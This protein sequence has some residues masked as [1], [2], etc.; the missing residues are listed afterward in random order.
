MPSF[1]K[2]TPA[3]IELFLD[4]QSPLDWTYSAVGATSGD[5]PAGYVV[6]QRHVPLGR[7]EAAF[8]QARQAIAQWRQFQLGWLEVWPPSAPVRAG[9]VVAVLARTVGMW[10][11]NACRIVYV[12]DEQEGFP[13]RFG[14]AYGTLPGHMESGEELFLVQMNSAGDVWYDIRAFSRPA[15]VL[16]RVGYPYARL[17]Q[18]R[19]GRD[20]ARVMQ[21]AVAAGLTA[22]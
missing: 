16:S 8:E 21:Q 4:E 3:T 1:R 13:R 12:V 17:V 11:L 10:W 2:P 15:H 20:S 7:G 18:K 14:F 6:D 19:F 5:V 9:Q 22:T